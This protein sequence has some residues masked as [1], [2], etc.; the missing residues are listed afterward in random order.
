MVEGD[1]N[2][3]AAAVENGARVDAVDDDDVVAR[4]HHHHRRGPTK[5]RRTRVA[6]ALETHTPAEAGVHRR[7]LSP[8][9]ATAQRHLHIS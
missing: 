2:D 9:E 8:G 4:Q 7:H 3:V 5:R 1:G 6:A